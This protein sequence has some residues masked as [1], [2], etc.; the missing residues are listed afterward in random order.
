MQLNL[1]NYKAVSLFSLVS[2]NAF[3]DSFNIYSFFFLVDE[4][5]HLELNT[6]LRHAPQNKV[7][8]W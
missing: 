4:T 3:T 7:P 1:N 6:A 2:Q 8:A 5:A